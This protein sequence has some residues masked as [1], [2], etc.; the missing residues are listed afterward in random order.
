MTVHDE[1]FRAPPAVPMAEQ[2]L[3]DNGGCLRLL[4]KHEDDVLYPDPRCR[5]M[6]TDNTSGTGDNIDRFSTAQVQDTSFIN[7]IKGSINIGYM[8]RDTE[9]ASLNMQF[10]LRTD[11]V[12]ALVQLAGECRIA[13]LK[14]ELS[15]VLSKRQLETICEVQPYIGVREAL[16]VA[17]ASSLPEDEVGVFTELYRDTFAEVW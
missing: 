1:I 4:G 14:G 9:V 15:L 5:L 8:P 17:F 6:Y 11:V 16:D 3:L 13:Y 2:S 12:E 10:D 7:R